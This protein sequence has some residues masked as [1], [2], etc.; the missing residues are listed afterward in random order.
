MLKFRR[1]VLVHTVS[2]FGAGCC[3]ERS[4]YRFLVTLSIY[5][6]CFHFFNNFL[7]S[8]GRPFSC[9]SS[10]T[11]H[12]DL[13]SDS[14]SYSGKVVCHS[15]TVT[16]EVLSIDG[17]FR[18]KLFSVIY[19]IVTSA[20]WLLILLGAMDEVS[21]L[22]ICKDIKIQAVLGRAWLMGIS[23]LFAINIIIDSR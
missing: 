17:V 19:I 1:E 5:L 16:K 7:A 23:L 15:T 13:K 2:D 22:F 21:L 6:S 12:V 4:F 14:C 9:G 8:Y 3:K 11:S 18:E 10:Y 20:P